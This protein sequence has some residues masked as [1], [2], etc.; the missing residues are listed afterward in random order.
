VIGIILSGTG[1]DGA[2][3]TRSLKEAGGFI[4]AQEPHTAKYDGMP[5]AAIQTGSVDKVLPPEKIG[6]EILEYLKNPG[7]IRYLENFDKEKD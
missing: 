4:I 5:L 3:G 6:E 7:Q 1:T 2:T